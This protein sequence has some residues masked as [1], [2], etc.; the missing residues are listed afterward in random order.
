MSVCGEANKAYNKS[1]RLDKQKFKAYLANR[2]GHAIAEK[3][4][5]M[6]NWSGSALTHEGYCK[7][8]EAVIKNRDVLY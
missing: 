3:Y 2:Y 5:Q 7:E 1:E 6:F 8:L 4:Y